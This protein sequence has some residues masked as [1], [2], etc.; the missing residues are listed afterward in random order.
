MAYKPK[1]V[2]KNAKTGLW[3]SRIELPSHDGRRRRL[4]KRSK[5]ARALD[6]YHIA[7]LNELRKY[8]DLPTSTPTVETFLTGWLVDK[9]KHVRPNTMT[10]YRSQVNHHIIPAIGKKRLAQLTPADVKNLHKAVIA[11]GGNSTYALNAHRVLS[12]A[13]SDAMDEGLILTNPAKRTRA[14]RKVQ[15]KLEALNLDESIR[16]LKHLLDSET[17]GARWAVSLLTGARRGEVI[18]LETDRV[19]THLDLSWQLQRIKFTHGCGQL[20]PFTRED[21]SMGMQG[22]C[23]MKS[24]GTC[25]ERVTADLPPDYEHRHVRGGLYLTRP[26]STDGW[27]VVPLVDPLKS[28]LERH[29]D[30]TKPGQFMFTRPDGTVHD[31]AQDTAEWRRV[32]QRSGISKDVRLHDLRHTAVDLLLA[33]GVPPEVVQ[34]IVGHSNVS[35]TLA[36]SSRANADPRLHA[37]MES[38]ATLLTPRQIGA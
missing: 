3:E 36:Y 31:P 19:G 20:V 16:L 15:P 4:V 22:A 13:L 28:I 17:E 33:A 11:A 25:P 12:T 23:G 5:D 29:I 24:G 6:D 18:G 38:L 26:K 30:D 1:H 9:A 14:P 34:R 10:N 27:R 2:K 21:G 37:A 35:Q 7:A 32:L 8:G